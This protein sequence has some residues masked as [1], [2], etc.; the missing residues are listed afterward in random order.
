MSVVFGPSYD[1]FCTMFV[2]FKYPFLTNSDAKLF[3]NLIQGTRFRSLKVWRV[4]GA[5]VTEMQYNT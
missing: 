5:L 2:T 3:M 4:N 1:N